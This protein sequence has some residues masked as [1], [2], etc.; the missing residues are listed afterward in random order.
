MQDAESARNKHHT[1]QRSNDNNQNKINQLRDEQEECETKL[2]KER[3]IWAAEMYELIAEENNIANYIIDYV[4]YQQQY[5]KSALNE[6]DKVMSHMNRL[7]S[8]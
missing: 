1:A 5:Y 6:I 7:I 8:K 3:D 2:E 4:K